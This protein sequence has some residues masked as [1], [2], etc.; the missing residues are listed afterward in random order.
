MN[1][2]VA[3]MTVATF[4]APRFI[5]IHTFTH[6]DGL[7]G[8]VLCKLLTGADIGWTGAAASIV[9]LVAIATERYFAVIHPHGNKRKL[10]TQKLKV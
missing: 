4:F 9:T 2:A 5:F 6:P 7:A 1:L 3:D 8:T 10:T